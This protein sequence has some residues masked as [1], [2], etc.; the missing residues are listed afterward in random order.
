VNDAELEA[1][2]RQG[3]LQLAFDTNA[4]TADRKF[5]NLCNDISR[6]NLM[7]E[8]QK[9]PKVR[10]VV[11]TVAHIEK[12]FD[13]KQRFR[14]IFDLDVILAGLQSKGVEVEPF[15][16]MH[17]LETALR[18]GES[19]PD[20][21]AW[22]QAKKNRCLGCVGLPLTTPAP[23]SGKYCGATVDWLIGGHAHASGCLLVTD[24][25]GVE[26]KG[27]ERIRLDRLVEALGKLL[28][29]SA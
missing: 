2:L 6:W 25:Q 4:L 21:E 24:D 5:R 8:A 28:G 1:R 29:G 9:L 17:A 18:L 22:H 15:S 13:L 11:C 19:Y 23:G 3:G 12:L 20:S 7:L 27:L 14:G 26:F 16:A 10:L